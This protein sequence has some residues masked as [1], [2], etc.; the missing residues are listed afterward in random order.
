MVRFI[1]N[2]IVYATAVTLTLLLIPGVQV[3]ADVTLQLW[4]LV[5]LIFGLLNA[6]V[7]PFLILFTGRLLIRSFGLFL[8][9]INAVLLW[10]LAWLF[11]FQFDNAVWLLTAGLL[12]GIILA[13]LDALFGLHRPLIANADEHSRLWSVAIKMAGNSS[14]QLITNLRLQQVYDI[15]YQSMLE[16]G[17]DRV[18]IISGIRQWVNQHILRSPENQ[19]A[20]LSTPAQIRVML[21]MLGPTFVKFGQMVSSRAEALPQE[22]QDEFAKLQSNVPPFDSAQ[23]MGIIEKELGAPIPTLFAQFDPVPFAAASTAQVHK[24]E[25]FDGTAVA[26]KV[27]RPN[28]VPK[29]KADLQILQEVIGTLSARSEVMRDN[30]ILG[31]FQEFASNLLEE[32]DYRN[33]AYNARRLADNMAQFPFIKVPAIYGQL[34]TGRVL[35]MEFVVGVKII[36]VDEIVAAGLTPKLI[37]GEFLEVMIKQIIFDGYFHGDAHPGN[38]MVNLTNGQ[39]VFLDM[40]MMG[41][42]NQEQRVNLGDLIWS[43]TGMDSYDLSEALLRLCTAFKDVH[44][45]KFREDIDKVVIRYMRY[46]MEAGSLSSVLNGVFAVLAENGLRLGRELTMALKTLVQAEQIVHT[47]DSELDITRESYELIR[48]FLAEQFNSETIRAS[49]QTQVMR[50]AKEVIRRIPDLQQATMQWLNQYEKGK[51]EVEINTDELNERLDIFNVAAQRLAVGIVLLGMIIG[52]AFAT[53]MEGQIFG[54]Q[55]SHVAFALFVVSLIIGT[56]MSIRMLRDV[57][58]RPQS[59][60]KDLVQVDMTCER[61]AMLPE[62]DSNRLAPVLR[63]LPGKIRGDGDGRSLPKPDHICR[64]CHTACRNG[65]RAFA[66][67]PGIT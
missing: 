8:I 41:T 40:G 28:I 55:L 20:G 50:S 44:I 21:Q 31:I 60:T 59:S 45:E 43:L 25:L 1:F 19:L 10:V 48:G 18:P 11:D 16:I 14:N 47:L 9:V 58:K 34:T 46:P 37:A 67:R 36:K 6:F 42:L 51:F 23:A 5:G 49:V 63:E 38:I 57:G 3:K 24:A 26:V 54:I 15:L 64:P 32:L 4:L 7:R 61:A 56:T 35:T 2:V 65:R 53:N 66:D 13:M 12:I 27:Q 22:W 39:I 30:D 62:R 33:E 29:I 17:L 52:S